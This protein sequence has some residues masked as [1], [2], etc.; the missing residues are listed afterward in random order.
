MMDKV[1][2]V[3]AGVTGLGVALLALSIVASL[4][5]GSGNMMVFG[6]AVKNITDL[7]TTL[8]SAGLPGLISIGVILWL[9]NR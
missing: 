8:G 7:V 3:V 1:N 9:F 5:V 2:K 4:L 6:E